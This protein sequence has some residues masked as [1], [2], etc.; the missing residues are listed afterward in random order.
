MKIHTILILLLLSLGM[1]SLTRGEE[2]VKITELLKTA[3][4]K[5][6]SNDLAGA[7]SILAEAI[8]VDDKDA[9]PYLLRGRLY[10]SNKQFDKALADYHLVLKLD[11]T[12]VKL[13]QHCGEL[14]F[15]QGNFK[16][17]V[18]DFDK[19]LEKF[20]SQIPYHWQ[21]GISQYYAGMYEAGVKQ[22]EIHRT[23]NPDDVENAVFHYIC[24]AKAKDKATAVKEFIPIQGDSRVPMM[25]IHALYAGKATVE[26]VLKAARAGF[27]GP[28]E[29]KSRLFY[30]HLYIGLWYD[31]EGKTKEAREYIFKAA[32][33]Y[34]VEG[35]MGDV[36]RVHAAVFRKQD[37]GKK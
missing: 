28:E 17:S 37:A 11:P 6:T 1:T 7:Q 30:A 19:V 20:P 12:A 15:R 31:A 26:D 3:N 2:N 27:P 36:A 22:F 9:R 4:Q 34:G 16:E 5:V 25:Q 24:L 33:Q 23:V 13:Y 10:E 8:K 21:R 29:L 32:D 35:Y 18:A 14:N